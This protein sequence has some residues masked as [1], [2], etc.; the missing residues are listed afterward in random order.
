MWRFRKKQSRAVPAETTPETIP[1]E[2]LRQVR[3]IEIRARRAVQEALAGGY[4]SVFRGRG[5]EFE[6]VREYV[7]GDDIRAI[8]WNVTA[9]MGHPFV[10]RFREERELTVLFL[11][12]VSASGVFGSGA[13]SKLE[14]AIELTALLMLT[15][16]RNH[17]KVGLLLFAE[18]VVRFLPARKDRGG[19]LRLLRE[20]VAARPVRGA[21]RVE[22]AL[23]Y[24]NRVQKKRAVV[25]L[26]SDFLDGDFSSLLATTGRRHDLVAVRIFD[27]REGA[28]RDAGLVRLVDAESG[29]TVEIDSASPRVRRWFGEQ[30]R[31]R[32]VRLR[33]AFQRAGVDLL[34]IDA[35]EDYEKSLLR[36]FRMRERRFR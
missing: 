14:R 28:L 34:E 35:D 6:E 32:T 22:R 9:R 29:A 7:P 36:F 30:A 1:P 2:I 4:H 19:A 21:T 3:R 15:A 27:A 10:K 5:M 26:I 18:D 11:V 12:D 31:A 17:D 13:R 25:F 23:D 8:D 16:L 24:V 20:L 33:A